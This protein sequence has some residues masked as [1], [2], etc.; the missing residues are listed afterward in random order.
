M[1]GLGEQPRNALG[2]AAI[3]QEFW[4]SLT[5][6]SLLCA[7]IGHPQKAMPEISKPWGGEEGEIWNDFFLNKCPNLLI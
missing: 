7:K 2:G 6:I 5:A 1:E 3:Q 4:G